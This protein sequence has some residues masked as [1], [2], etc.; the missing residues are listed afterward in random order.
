LTGEEDQRQHQQDQRDRLNREKIERP[1]RSRY[2]ADHGEREEEISEQFVVIQHATA[3]LKQG[4]AFQSTPGDS[5]NLARAWIQMATNT[6][7]IEHPAEEHR[8]GNCANYAN[9]NPLNSQGK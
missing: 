5:S 4:G 2:L 6:R 1:M 3:V 8:G 7:D 9:E